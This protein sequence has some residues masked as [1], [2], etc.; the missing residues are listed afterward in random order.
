MMQSLLLSLRPRNIS[1]MVMIVVERGTWSMLSRGCKNF[2]LAVW[3]DLRNW[4]CQAIICAVTDSELFSAA[5]ETNL[6]KGQCG[7]WSDTVEPYKLDSFV[8]T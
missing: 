1:A 6:A 3:V 7:L 4:H 8:V 2:R 5:I